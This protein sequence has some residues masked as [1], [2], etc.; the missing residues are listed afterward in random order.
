MAKST[1]KYL[2]LHEAEEETGLA[3][4]ELRRLIHEGALPGSYRPGGKGQWLVPVARLTAW[5]EREQARDH[6][7][8]RPQRTRGGR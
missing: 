2:R 5:L 6:Y 3:P 4:K 7:A 1:K 8:P